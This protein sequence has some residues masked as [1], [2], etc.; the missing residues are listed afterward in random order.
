MVAVVVV[1]SIAGLLAV[2][3]PQ[4]QGFLTEADM[5]R[6]DVPLAEDGG[7]FLAALVRETDH[8]RVLVASEAIIPFRRA[9]VARDWDLGFDLRFWDLLVR[10]RAALIIAEDA[11]RAARAGDPGRVRQRLL[12]LDRLARYAIMEPAMNSQAVGSAT[13][14]LAE[15]AARGALR[16][17]GMRAAVAAYV[18]ERGPTADL[19][20]G[21]RA[22]LHY[23]GW[24]TANGER[25]REIGHWTGPFSGDESWSLL[26]YAP[27][28]LAGVMGAWWRAPSLDALGRVRDAVVQS[29]GPLAKAAAY[30]REM[31]RLMD[32]GDLAGSLARNSVKAPG[33]RGAI[34]RD[35]LE[36]RR[37]TDELLRRTR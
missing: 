28:P 9:Y 21:L 31:G 33:P 1:A 15:A 34:V 24:A 17:P 11:R 36:S 4:P 14:L 35:D 16:R 18:A 10:R 25:M 37:E 5:A 29:R 13:R 19:A 26:R 8:S 2:P 32:G 30:D 22:D 7:R 6:N 23:A 3:A 12:A 27:K 20:H